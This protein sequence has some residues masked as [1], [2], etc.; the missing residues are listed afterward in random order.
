MVVADAVVASDSARA[1][2]AAFSDG[3]GGGDRRRVLLLLPR[4]CTAAEAGP[5]AGAVECF[6]DCLRLR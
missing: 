4:E 6:L 3:S 1:K 5:A 2:C